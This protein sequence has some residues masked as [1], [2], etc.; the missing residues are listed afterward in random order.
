MGGSLSEG[1]RIVF[2]IVLACLVIMF[3]VGVWRSVKQ[4]GNSA[5]TKINN[6]AAQMDEEDYEQYDGEPTV[7]STVLNIIKQHE[8]DPVYIKVDGVQYVCDDSLKALSNESDLIKAAKDK[9]SSSYI[10][11][12]RMYV[13]K[14]VRNETTNALMGLEFTKQ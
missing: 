4:T 13:G 14:V 10:S 11:P 1:L 3:G 2:A 12:N 8:N 7:G 6:V 5:S 9:T